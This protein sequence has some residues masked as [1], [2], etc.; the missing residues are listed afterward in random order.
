MNIQQKLLNHLNTLSLYFLF[1]RVVIDILVHMDL[2]H[3]NKFYQYLV[4]DLLD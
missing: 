1:R 2:L 4:A 3:I